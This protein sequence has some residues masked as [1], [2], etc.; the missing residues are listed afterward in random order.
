LV[1][2]R[3]IKTTTVAHALN[4]HGWVKD[5][6]AALSVQVLVEYLQ[7]WNLVDGVILLQDTPDQFHWKLTQSGIYS[8]KSTYVAFFQGT[9][10]KILKEDS[11]WKRIWR[12]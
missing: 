12:S 4:N 1:P 9:I 10:K 6:R 5:I 7:I 11:P 8:S 3:I 2:K